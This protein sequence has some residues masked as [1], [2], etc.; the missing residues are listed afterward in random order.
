MGKRREKFHENKW[1]S[2]R[3]F[4]KKN[5]GFKIRKVNENSGENIAQTGGEY[6]TKRRREKG[7]GKLASDFFTTMIGVFG[8]Y[9]PV[10]S[11]LAV[12]KEL[13]Q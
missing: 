11:I 10:E 4:V 9:C 8:S 12:L 6:V 1:D 13:V 7:K 5:Q 2:S 3:K